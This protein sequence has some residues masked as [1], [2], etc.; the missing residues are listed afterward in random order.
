MGL[1]R[2]WVKEWVDGMSKRIG[3][4]VG[5]S[6]GSR[7]AS[8]CPRRH[9]RSPE[10]GPGNS[11]VV[12]VPP[13]HPAGDAPAARNAGTAL[14]GFESPPGGPV[15]VS[16]LG[17]YVPAAAIPPNKNPAKRGCCLVEVVGVEPTSKTCRMAVLHR[18][19]PLLKPPGG[20]RTSR[21]GRVS[22]DLGRRQGTSRQPIWCS[23]RQAEAT[24]SE[25]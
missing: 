5:G 1:F 20:E 11:A 13:H 15:G 18:L 21:T 12:G 6:R 9:E 14:Y 23:V 8:P 16:L 25:V 3:V 24:L 2:G 17:A 22:P 7:F 10:A 19:G 4:L